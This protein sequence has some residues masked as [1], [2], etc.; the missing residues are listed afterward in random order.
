[1]PP[2]V[3]DVVVTVGAVALIGLL[4]FA[5]SGLWPPMVAVESGSM[6]PEMHRGDMIY[7]V[8]EHRETPNIAYGSTGVVT[9]SIGETAGYRTFGGPGDV[10]VYRPDGRAGTTPVIHRA[11][12]WVNESENWHDKADP[13]LLDGNTCEAVRNC[14]APHPGFVTKGDNNDYYDQ[15]RGIS[16]PVRPSWVIG[17]AEVRVPGLGYVRLAV[18]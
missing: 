8:E 1:V 17:T 7:V 13:R 6:E 15:T 3:R 12:F 4:L 11:R 14:P 18:Q 16:S 9:A 10:V 5:I 2:L